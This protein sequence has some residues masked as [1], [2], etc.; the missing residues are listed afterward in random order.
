MFKTITFFVQLYFLVTFLGCATVDKGAQAVGKTA[1]K[2]VDVMHTTSETAVKVIREE[3]QSN[4]YN[5]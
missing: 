4:P 1:G 2:T 3:K 5:R